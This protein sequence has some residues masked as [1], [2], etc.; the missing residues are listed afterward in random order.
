MCRKYEEYKIKITYLNGDTEELNYKGINTSNYKEMLKLYKDIKEQYKEE[1]VVID[2]LG[3][4]NTGE[5]GI[6]FTKEIKGKDYLDKQELEMTEEEILKDIQRK[7]TLLYKRKDETINKL[8]AV[9]K[10]QDILL[11]QIE[12]LPSKT[13]N[14]IKI[15]MLN[16]LQEI[17]KNRRYLKNKKN[18]LTSLNIIID[19]FKILSNINT[20]TKY[21]LDKKQKSVLQEQQFN[22]DKIEKVEKRFNVIKEIKYRNFRERVNLI[23]QLTP[24]YDKV[25][26]DDS[27]MTVTCYNKGYKTA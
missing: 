3:I 23:K 7:M 14:N 19:N 1:S 10:K 26:Y 8:N 13:N 24:K 18:D 11:H 21:I 25:Y 16:E 27:K 20:L 5:L 2:F 4:T 17:R 6:L 12:S 15:K 22:F 9:N